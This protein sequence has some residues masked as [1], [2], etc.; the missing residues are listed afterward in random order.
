MTK[1]VDL[2][3]ML[4]DNGIER[5]EVDLP[6]IVVVGDQSTGKSSLIEGLRFVLIFVS[7]LILIICS[8]IKVPRKE[9]TCTR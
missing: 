9:G 6:Q 3:T 2:I 4:R 8:A 1:L 5:L 7:D